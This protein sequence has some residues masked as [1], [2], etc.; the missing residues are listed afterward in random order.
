MD[1]SLF[2][3]SETRDRDVSK[4]RSPPPPSPTSQSRKTP[5]FFFPELLRLAQRHEQHARPLLFPF[6]SC[7]RKERVEE[8]LLSPPFFLVPNRACGSRAVSWGSALPF[9]SFPLSASLR[10][11]E[12]VGDSAKSGFLSSLLSPVV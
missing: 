7:F 8:N 3:P 4:R 6:P 5:P 2:P 12:R 10:A 9:F 1:P 11:S